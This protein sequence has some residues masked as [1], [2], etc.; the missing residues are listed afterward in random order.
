MQI[1]VATALIAT[2]SQAVAQTIVDGST[3]EE[4]ESAAVDRMMYVVTADFLDPVAAQFRRLM[5]GWIPQIICGEVNGKNSN[6]AY[7]GFKPFYYNINSEEFDI[8]DRENPIDRLFFGL[9]ADSG[10]ARALG[11][12]PPQE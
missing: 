11:I 12:D 1:A 7:T 10:C 8:Y 9:L 2:A 5:P 3:L 6:G 4:V